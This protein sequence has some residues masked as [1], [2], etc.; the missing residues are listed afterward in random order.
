MEKTQATVNTAKAEFNFGPAAIT[1]FL[2]SL[3]QHSAFHVQFAVLGSFG[4]KAVSIYGL[5]MVSKEEGK[6]RE[7]LM[8][9]SML[10]A[11]FITTCSTAMPFLPG[12]CK[13]I[14]NPVVTHVLNTN[15]LFLRHIICRFG[16]F[17]NCETYQIF[18]L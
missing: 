3:Y 5:E 16:F 6:R 2:V 8:V 7:N 9:L 18:F 11:F 17:C 10:C 12:S 4:R 1:Q 14:L 13:K 15:F